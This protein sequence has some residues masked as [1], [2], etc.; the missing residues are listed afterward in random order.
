LAG[1]PLPAE[2]DIDG[3]SLVPLLKGQ[4]IAE[5]PLFWH[6]PHYGNQGGEPSSIISQDDWKLIHYHEDGRDELYHLATD[7]GEQKDLAAAEPQRVKDLRAKLDAWL[8]ATDARFPT[9][10]PQF[11][12]AKRAARWESLK[13]GGK[14]SLEKRHA[15]Y[16]DADYQPNK[17][18]WGSHVTRD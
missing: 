6:Y 2:Q 15:S 16:L 4:S 7:P 10:D 18:W 11:D 8:Q 3:V 12:A 9:K 5:R 1:F 13:T 17:D 14:A